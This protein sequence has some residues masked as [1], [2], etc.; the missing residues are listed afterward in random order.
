MAI[1]ERQ[2]TYKNKLE[3]NIDRDVT[4]VTQ[5]PAEKFPGHIQVKTPWELYIVSLG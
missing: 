3:D 1:P 4:S 2:Q 5:D